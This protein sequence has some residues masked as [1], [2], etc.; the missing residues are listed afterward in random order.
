[1]KIKKIISA[2]LVIL[3]S[4][5][6]MILP[7]SVSANSTV[8][9]EVTYSYDL[10]L[11]E[12][13]EDFQAV[14][15]FDAQ[16]YQVASD[17]EG[18]Y[19]VSFPAFGEDIF[20]KVKNESGKILFN[21]SN[22]SQKYDFTNKAT[23]VTVT[24]DVISSNVENNS[25]ATLNIVETSS[26]EGNT[27]STDEENGTLIT[28]NELSGKISDVSDSL[29]GFSFLGASIHLIEP[30]EMIFGEYVSASAL[31]L[32][33]DYGAVVMHENNYSSDM[34]GE[35]MYS[36]E[37]AIIL[38]KTNGK[39]QIVNGSYLF[40]TLSQ[41]LYCYDMD[42][43]YYVS[44]FVI[45]DGKKYFDS[46]S[47]RNYLERIQ[48]CISTEQNETNL[49]V[50]NDMYDLYVADINYLNSIGYTTSTVPKENRKTLHGSDYT[51]NGQEKT[52]TF[53]MI[54]GGASI[55]LVEPWGLIFA[56]AIKTSEISNSDEY[57]F[58]ILN[59]KDFED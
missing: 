5:T 53:S 9:G 36:D 49:A 50:Y 30:W 56:E 24:F 16:K 7:F 14:L 22:Y 54:F 17:D 13:V 41:G 4:A 28:D 45:I 29:I 21:A 6:I 19:K 10:K 12:A 3:M 18:N 33:D 37:N 39:S 34:T 25:V 58:V 57:G 20:Y 31:A 44:S 55:H 42:T 51:M 38:S 46:V 2:L 59:E 23:V 32:S 40:N 47:V 48:S 52:N 27:Y 1:M 15:T 35:D 26:E 11:P 43:D 8:Y